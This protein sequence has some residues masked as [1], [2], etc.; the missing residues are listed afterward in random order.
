MRQTPEPLIIATL[1]G[2]LFLAALDTQLLIPL[3]PL[4]GLD[5]EVSMEKLGWLLSLYALAAALFSLLLGPLTDRLG[6]VFFLRL[7][8]ALFIVLAL[9]T[10]RVESYLGL[11]WLR[12]GTGLAGGV[13]STCTASWVGDCFPYE[14][15]GRVMGTVLS[16]YFAALIVGIPLSTWIAQAWGWHRVFLVSAAA[17]GALLLSLA[18]FFRSGEAARPPA[19]RAYFQGYPDFLRQPTT[20][21][22]LL[23]SFAASGA[24]LAFLTFISAYLNQSFAVSPLQISVLFFLVGCASALGSPLSGWMSDRWTKR[25]VFLVSNTAMLLPLLLLDRL[26]WG[27]PLMAVFF[28]LGVCAAFRQT[29]LQTVQTELVESQERGAFIALRNGFSQIGISFSVFVAGHLYAA[30]GYGL[31]L[32]W[33]ALLTCLSSLIFYLAVPEPCRAGRE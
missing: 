5:L 25:N 29:A 21:A 1:F 20:R 32:A 4:L 13:L 18:L 12:A 24:T 28:A 19:G 8:L 15:R 7:G 14:R 26:P 17:G 23:V 6:R 9:A 22:A 30:L 3:F 10:A 31:V 27:G 16:A 33:A 2:V 11:A